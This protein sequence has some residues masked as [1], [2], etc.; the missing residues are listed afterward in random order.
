MAA[1]HDK[2]KK[3]L[4]ELIECGERL[5]RDNQREADLWDNE[6]QRVLEAYNPK[7]KSNFLN[8]GE[9][10]IAASQAENLDN[11]WQNI[12]ERIHVLR[13]VLATLDLPK[14]KSGVDPLS[15]TS[16]PLGRR[17]PRWER[18]ERRIH[19]NIVAGFSS[20]FVPVALRS[21]W[22]GSLNL[23]HRRFATGRSRPI[24]MTAV[25]ATG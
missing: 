8:A 24:A 1:D 16:D 6:C 9:L 20:W 3:K 18:N 22:L 5:S 4:E 11:W 12:P 21:L 2:W 19:W 15:W 25:A 17:N 10:A 13:A 23:R 14:R 7:E